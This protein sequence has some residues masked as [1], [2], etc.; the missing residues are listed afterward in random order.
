[1]LSSERVIFR[2]LVSI[3]EALKRV[4]R[5]INL[6]PLGSLRVKI[7]DALGMVLAKDVY[8][9]IDIPP[10]NRA[11]Y[12]GYAVYASDVYG[13]SET[14]PVKL[15][16]V[17]SVETGELGKI[18]INRGEAVEIATGAVLPDGAD[19]VV[20]VEYTREEGGYVYVKRP[21]HPGENVCYTGSD[22]H[23]GQL[24]CFRGERINIRTISMLAAVGIGVVDVYRK[25]VVGVISTGK[26]LLPPGKDLLRGKIYDINSYSLTASIINSGGKPV[27]LGVVEDNLED[28]AE[29][30]L[31]AL[32]EADIVLISGSSSAGPGDMV[33]KVFD[34]LD[35]KL[36]FHGVAMKPGKPTL[37]GLISGKPVFG[38][39]GYPV[40]CLMAYKVFVD[41]VISNLAGL[42]DTFYERIQAKLAIR[43][44]TFGRRQLVPVFLNKT[45]KDFIAHP[46]PGG[47]GTITRLRNADGFIIIPEDSE[48]MD[49]GETVS[50]DL[51]E[52]KVF[53]GLTVVAEYCPFFDEIL[54]K[55][56]STGARFRIILMESKGAFEALKYGASDVAGVESLEGHVGDGLTRIFRYTRTY[57]FASKSKLDLASLTD[58]LLKLGWRVA[59]RGGNTAPGKALSR[60]LHE[61]IGEKADLVL[62]NIYRLRNERSVLRAVL[63]ETVNLG[64]TLSILALKNGLNFIPV[65]KI[66]YSVLVRDAALAKPEVKEF[67]DFLNKIKF[68]DEV[69]LLKRRG[70][71][72]KMNGG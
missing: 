72:N 37:F 43:I 69:E 47:S 60:Y 55:Y 3:E 57:G 36:V 21:V 19:A 5:E 39:P 10:F 4:R 62:K 63:D 48:F 14:N 45:S 25:P 9:P 17:G 44:H 56:R 32:D 18:A 53:T 54:G 27:R 61:M 28:L 12:D 71:L 6:K 31:K 70:T 65:R 42:R 58:N 33:Y 50:V 2:E 67:M 15:K 8:S 24:I 16:L 46:V 38:L 51:F 23:R 40:S 29:R 64:F 66:N 26:E 59:C 22:I 68:K 13:A 1:M 35:G 34:R 30:V 52:K 20:M 49:K 41:P 7:E 11:A